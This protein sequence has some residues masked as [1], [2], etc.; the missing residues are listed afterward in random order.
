MRPRENTIMMKE[1]KD[2]KHKLSVFKGKK[3][4]SSLSL[5]ILKRKS[6]SKKTQKK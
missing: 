2:D 3:S 4:G 6:K 1:N 5:V